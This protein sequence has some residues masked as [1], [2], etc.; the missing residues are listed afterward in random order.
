M[1]I[2]WIQQIF[3]K[4]FINVKNINRVYKDIS[5]NKN[6]NGVI[7]CS[8]FDII[9]K[10]FLKIKKEFYIDKI[11]KCWIDF[12]V[13][14]CCVYRYYFEMFQDK[15]IIGEYWVYIPIFI[16]DIC[17]IP[18]FLFNIGYIIIEFPKR[19]M[20][21]NEYKKLKEIKM[22]LECVRV[23]DYNEYYLYKEYNNSIFVNSIIRYYPKSLMVIDDNTIKMKINIDNLKIISLIIDEKMH[24][25]NIDTITLIKN[26]KNIYIWDFG[27]DTIFKIDF[28][29]ICNEGF[30]YDDH[31]ELEFCFNSK[32]TVKEFQE[33]PFWF[34]VLNEIDL[35]KKNG[36]TNWEI[37][38][39]WDFYK[40]FIFKGDIIKEEKCCILA[41]NNG[42]LLKS[43]CCNQF[44]LYD[45]IKKYINYNGKYWEC[46]HC[47][48]RDF[49]WIIFKKITKE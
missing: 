36:I 25:N 9:N 17:G 45:F 4:N 34:E 31:H 40:N 15:V 44:F 16:A 10:C 46:P 13:N 3:K 47:R 35:K 38:E 5:W 11:H 42:D 1:T 43:K 22:I 49:P 7:L 18:L 12:M 30:I 32:I 27:I 14:D 41:D 24:K 23:T 21:N 48:G 39:K 26:D 20:S 6:R 33:L 19:I 8:N 2:N 29:K 28:G 37:K